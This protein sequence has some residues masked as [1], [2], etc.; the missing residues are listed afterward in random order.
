MLV[1]WLWLCALRSPV[2]IDPAAV[3]THLDTTVPTRLSDAGIEGVVV[4]VATRDG[5]TVVGGWGEADVDAGT[6]MDGDDTVVRVASISKTFTATA[7][8]GLAVEGKLDLDA[9]VERYLGGLS[10]PERS[11]PPVTLRHLLS[12]TSG[13]INNNVG[14][15]A[16]DAPPQPLREFLAATMPPRIYAPATGVIYSNHGNA[17]AGLA[18]QEVTG[19]PFERHVADALLQPL[20]MASS[21][22]TLDDDLASRLAKSYVGEPGERREQPY[23]YFG[24]V[25]ASA[26]HT[27]A[28]D[29]ARYIRFQLGDGTLDGTTVLPTEA[30]RRLRTPVNP[31]HPAL[32]GYHLAF[33]H[34]TTAGHPTR[35]HGGSAP[36]FLSKLVLFE[37]LGVGIFVCQNGF[38]PS[39]TADIVDDFAA[40]FLPSPPPRPELAAADDGR[41]PDPSAVT[42]RY[43]QLNKL[44][45]PAFT[46]GRTLVFSHRTVVST[47][48][49]G[50]LTVGGDRFVRTGDDVYAR[51]PD[52]GPRQTVVFSRE[53]GVVT[54]VHRDATS[55]VR[56][57]WHAARW[58]QLLAYGLAFV[59]LV[60]VRVAP[61]AWNKI[62]KGH[63]WPVVAGSYVARFALLGVI[64]PHLYALWVDHGQPAYLTPLRFGMP[65]WLVVVTWLPFVVLPI[66]LLL[67]ALQIRRRAPRRLV[68]LA[69]AACVA[70]AMLCGLESYWRTGPVGLVG[71]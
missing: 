15:V 34:G 70:I 13:V 28:A 18:V 32:P 17:L 3:R 60:V 42:G 50:Y 25:P 65:G 52:D 1:L 16:T 66:G 30:M 46:R 58:L 9:N 36:A 59:V 69:A 27:T 8:V 47:D 10:F 48:D 57:P 67:V 14:R 29:M 6:P 2:A 63:R 24:T 71:A 38:G 39:L 35:S 12:H 68:W 7:I 20:G 41:P 51:D 11:H 49:D 22:F 55:S 4:S 64:G 62:P 61:L 54:A 23:L 53:D 31:I 40:H 44:D 37:D 56:D 43:R 5:V 33:F 26:L 21:S 19:A 45:N